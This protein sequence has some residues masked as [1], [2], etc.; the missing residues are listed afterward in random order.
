ML[1]LRAV[2]LNLLTVFEAVYEERNQARAA[3]RLAMTQPAVSNAIARL[4]HVVRDPLFVPA[5][6]G[7]IPTPAAERLYPRVREALSSLREG[8]AGERG[9]DPRTT[10]AAFDLMIGYGGG[11]VLGPPLLHWIEREAPRARLRI[12]SLD[13]P[14]TLPRRLRDGQLD[15]AIDY[16][17]PV[18]P[19]LA[20]EQVGDARPVVI[21]RSDHPRVRGKV[22]RAVL[23]R[24]RLATHLE[25]HP[26]GGMREIEAVLA[27]L[28][29]HVAI[30]VA[31]ALAL[32][33]VVAATDL[34]AVVSDTVAEVY[35]RPL[36][37]AIH[38][39]PVPVAP[40][41]VFLIWHR[42]HDADPAQRWLRDGIRRVV[43]QAG[44][45]PRAGAK[46]RR[47]A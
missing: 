17:A 20:H 6:R 30:E 5:S 31:T 18:D 21:V 38:P 45:R 14:A 35:A 13:D 47:P 1:N 10:T 28:A 37:L 44:R 12:R 9:F 11:A 26:G 40:V 7:V 19:D 33:A 8:L 32:P 36:G 15:A 39:F 41:P 16:V 29:P 24:E 23:S 4:R 3:E 25:R 34:I 42:S 43:A 22:T 27:G 2:D 46:G